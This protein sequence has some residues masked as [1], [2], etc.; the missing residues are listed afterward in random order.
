MVETPTR[1][2]T[3]DRVIEA[4]DG[5]HNDNED[6][7]CEADLCHDL[8]DDQQEERVEADAEGSTSVSVNF[9]IAE[10]EL[11]PPKIDECDKAKNETFFRLLRLLVTNEHQSTAILKDAIGLYGLIN[12][13]L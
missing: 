9:S 3:F 6:I 13:S 12:H 11:Q 1:N 2:I 10:G 4:R 5:Y 8:S 7:T